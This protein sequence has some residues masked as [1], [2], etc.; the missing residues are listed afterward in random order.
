MGE[1]IPNK[2]PRVGILKA[3]GDMDDYIEHDCGY[4]HHKNGR[5]PMS[6]E[7]LEAAMVTA[8]K[9]ADVGRKRPSNA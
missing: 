2:S 9:M 5:C 8:V 7:Q 1:A 6:I 3:R 4:F